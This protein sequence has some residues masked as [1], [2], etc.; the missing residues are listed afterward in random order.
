MAAFI[1]PERP[2]SRRIAA[3]AT[4]AESLALANVL[5]TGDV[6]TEEASDGGSPGRAAV[7]GGDARQGVDDDVVAEDSDDPGDDVP[8]MIGGATARKNYPASLV[9]TLGLELRS[10]GA[11]PTGEEVTDAEID[12]HLPETMARVRELAVWSSFRHLLH[13]A[14]LDDVRKRVRTWLRGGKGKGKGG[15]QETEASRLRKDKKE[16]ADLNARLKAKNEEE[17]AARV[18]RDED[19]LAQ[20]IDARESHLGLGDNLTYDE[21]TRGRRIVAYLDGSVIPKNTG[22]YRLAHAHFTLLVYLLQ[23]VREI[24]VEGSGEF[25]VLLAREQRLL[26]TIVGPGQDWAKEYLQTHN[27]PDP[28]ASP[29]GAFGVG[30]SFAN[31][32]P[33]DTAKGQALGRINLQQGRTANGFSRGKDLGDP[34]GEASLTPGP[35]SEDVDRSNSSGASS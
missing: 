19:I 8:I 13:D 18:A 24:K 28:S 30:I 34:K 2:S 11:D 14:K 5:E 23:R 20:V 9:Q 27:A 22:Q 6:P 16:R 17:E 4:A 33:S 1:A 12:R 26:C 32:A 31:G 29:D 21:R 10:R 25:C 7:A 15:G 3:R 35:L